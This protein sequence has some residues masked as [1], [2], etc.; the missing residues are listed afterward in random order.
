MKVTRQRCAGCPAEGLL[1]ISAIKRTEELRQQALDRMDGPPALVLL[2]ESRPANRFIYDPD[3]DYDSRPGLR[4]YLRRELT[5]TDDDAALFS[6]LDRRRVWIADCALCP[7]YL[8]KTNKQKRLAA[9]ECLLRYT[10]VHL[11]QYPEVPIAT[12][13]PAHRGFLKLEVPDIQKRVVKALDFSDL[14]GL[15]R[16]VEAVS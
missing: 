3:A 4:T 11:D 1:D 9:T 10:R 14:S 7:L 6:F 15:R 16:L 12:V 8:L 5:G 13:F 2:A